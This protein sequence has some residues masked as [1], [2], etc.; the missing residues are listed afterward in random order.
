M[1]YGSDSGHPA[2]GGGRTE[3]AAH[4]HARGG[5][6][7]I[8]DLPVAQVDGHV[9]VAPEDEVAGLTLVP[10]NLASLGYLIIS[11]PTEADPGLSV[12]C[13]RKAG[14]V[15][16]VGAIG[17]QPVVGVGAVGGVDCPVHGDLS[18]VAAAAAGRLDVG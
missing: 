5:G 13:L 3:D 16:G 6:A 18:G 10:R 2:H 1:A 14:A 12:C 15:P 8:D 4:G 7:G 11:R 9:I 17:A